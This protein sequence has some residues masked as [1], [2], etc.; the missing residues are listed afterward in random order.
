MSNVVEASRF[1]LRDSKGMVRAALELV[2]K[3]EEPHLFLIDDRGYGRVH[4]AL[5]GGRPLI[6]LMRADGS[7]A[8]GIGVGEEGD[9][10][11]GATFD[12]KGIWRVDLR[13]TQ[14]GAIVLTR[15]DA[16]GQI[17]GSQRFQ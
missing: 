1:V 5:D 10:G 2:G 11:M 9:A 13:I 7:Q 12:A 4:V 6:G 3:E 16:N 15:Y 8:I 17:I 14:D